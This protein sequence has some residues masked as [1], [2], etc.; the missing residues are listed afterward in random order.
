MGFFG[1]FESKEEKEKKEI[2]EIFKKINRFLNDDDMQNNGLPPLFRHMYSPQR[3]NMIPGGTGE[4]G[5]NPNNPIPVNGPIGEVTYLSKLLVE[6]TN[7]KVFFHRLGSCK[8]HIDIYELFSHSGNF[9]DELYLDMY[10]LH[11]S[12]FMPRGY[13]FQN[14]VTGIRGINSFCEDLP[15]QFYDDLVQFTKTRIGFP[16]FDPDA[17]SIRFERSSN[18]LNKRN[19]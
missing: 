13:V 4:F 15:N 6:G 1:L 17:K 12:Q 16:A 10:F 5:R 9:N 18:I 8:G 7:E 2:I 19:K 3:I 14:E 11:K